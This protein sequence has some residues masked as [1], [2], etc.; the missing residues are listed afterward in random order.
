MKDN[1]KNILKMLIGLAYT[2]VGLVVFLT[3]AHIGFMPVANMLGEIIGSRNIRWILIPLGMLMGFF[4]VMAEPAVSV[5]NK[6]VE[7]LS[8]GAIS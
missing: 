7:E 4:V 5:L 6:Q 1:K 3:G 8:S 2:Y